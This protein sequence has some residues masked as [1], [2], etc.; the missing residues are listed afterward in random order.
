MPRVIE[1]LLGRRQAD[2]V[3]VRLLFTRLLDTKAADH[4]PARECLALMA[5]KVQTGEISS[6][7]TAS[8]R[9]QIEPALHQILDHQPVHPLRHHAAVLAVTLKDPKGIAIVQQGFTES[10]H[11]EALRLQSLEA[12]IAGGD[13]TVLNLVA[14]V[15]GQAEGSSLSFRGQV[16]AALGKL[17]DPRVASLVL[18]HYPHLEPDLKP[19]AIELLI[20]RVRWSKPLLEAIAAKKVPADALNV[21]Q[22]RRM[23]ASKDADLVQRVKAQWGTIRDG[24][25]PEREKVVAEMRAFLLNARGDARAGTQVFKNLCAQCHK[26]HG[27]GQD[28]GPD[29]TVNGRASFEQLLSNV[30]DPSLVIGA[31]YQATTVTTVRGRTLTGLLVEDNAQRVV[32]K[33]QGGKTETIARR[34]VEE[35]TVSPLSLM[36]EGI[37]KQLKPQE[38]ADL[39]AFLTLDKPPSDP[40]AKKIPGTPREGG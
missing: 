38:I 33:L 9:Q 6:E 22:V 21:N 1:R 24:R 13:A 5:A 31:A 12:L 10:R 26:I 4:G 32:L 40:T 2:P 36:P 15:L 17:D 29:I 16:L 39:F 23:L 11:S 14:P 34:E 18:T 25:N 30:F 3:L 20:Q 19:R 37:E 8:L 28:V 27:E 35:I 7:K